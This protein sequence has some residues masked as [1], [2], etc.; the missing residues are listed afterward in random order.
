MNFLSEG[1]LIEG[2]IKNGLFRRLLPFVTISQCDNMLLGILN[3]YPTFFEKTEFMTFLENKLTLQRLNL[4]HLPW[5]QADNWL[6][7]R[8]LK[9]FWSDAEVNKIVFDLTF[10]VV[11]YQKVLFV[12]YMGKPFLT[13]FL[14]FYVKT[15]NKV[16]MKLFIIFINL[17]T[18]RK[19]L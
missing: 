9:D 15:I 5:L 10:S 3:S 8:I 18:I 2:W 19:G 16:I 1:I 17:H 11:C 12:I 14:I 13:S 7:M 6:H 4:G